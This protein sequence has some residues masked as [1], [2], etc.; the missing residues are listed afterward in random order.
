[1][2]Y[3][4]AKCTS[5]LKLPYPAVTAVAIHVVEHRTGTE[6]AFV[7]ALVDE[8]QVS[9]PATGNSS[10]YWRS[11]I[12]MKSLSLETLTSGISVNVRYYK[13]SESNPANELLKAAR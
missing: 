13:T 8:A 2:K 7:H 4:S 6:G 3:S 1:M 11:A 12:Q 5:P 9:T 10:A